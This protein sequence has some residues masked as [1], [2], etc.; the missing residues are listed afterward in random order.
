MIEKLNENVRS[1]HGPAIF[2]GLFVPSYLNELFE[3][4]FNVKVFKFK[5]FDNQV[6]SVY[7]YLYKEGTKKN[8]Y[9]LLTSNNNANKIRKKK[10]VQFT[11]EYL[12]APCLTPSM[13]YTFYTFS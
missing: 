9:I 5:D 13:K 1:S 12:F 2:H 4:Y 6:L 11:N 7:L 10:L 8:F 3:P